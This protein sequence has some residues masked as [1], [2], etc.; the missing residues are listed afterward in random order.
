MRNQQKGKIRR[1]LG[2]WWIKCHL[3]LTSL[4]KIKNWQEMKFTF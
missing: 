3:V 4:E 1:E 2:I